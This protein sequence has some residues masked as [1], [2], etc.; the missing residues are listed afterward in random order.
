MGIGNSDRYF[1]RYSLIEDPRVEIYIDV[2]LA[3]ETIEVGSVYHAPLIGLYISYIDSVLIGGRTKFGFWLQENTP[4]DK[5]AAKN[6]RDSNKKDGYCYSLFCYIT[7]LSLV[8][9]YYYTIKK[10]FIA[11]L[12]HIR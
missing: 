1:D 10:S 6:N 3:K 2:F 5:K 7:Y 9:F 4:E 8:N 12:S 11:M